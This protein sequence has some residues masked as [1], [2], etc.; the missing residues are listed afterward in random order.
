M[1]SLLV[2]FGQ[3]KDCLRP[4]GSRSIDI[5]VAQVGRTKL[6]VRPLEEQEQ[7]KNTGLGLVKKHYNCIIGLTGSI[8]HPCPAA[9]CPLKFHN[10]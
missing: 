5:N 1:I 7:E 9:L 3:Q 8:A 2:L 10:N 6:D 4:D